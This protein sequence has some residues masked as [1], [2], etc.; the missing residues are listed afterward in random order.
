MTLLYPEFSVC[1]QTPCLKRRFPSLCYNLGAMA[2]HSKWAQI[3]RQKAVKDAK[4][5]AAFAKCAHEIMKATSLGGPDPAGNFRLRTAIEKA[6][7][8][9]LPNDNIHRAIA[10]GSGQGGADQMDAMVYEGYGPGGAAILIEAMT[11]NKNRTAGDIRSYFNKCE[12]NLGADGCVAW[13]FKE[14]GLIKISAKAGDESVL[15]DKAIEA[16]AQDFQNSPEED[17][18]EILTAPADLNNVCER[19]NAEGLSI[20]S[21]EMTRTCENHVDITDLDHAKRLLKL[22]DLIESH[23]DVQAVYSNFEMSEAL[24]ARLSE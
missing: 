21:A 7:A 8:L 19:L 13:M 11:D 20:Q 16:G 1:E 18:F 5:G 17:C 22:L 6:K 23:D 15:F 14:Q 4:K 12:G 10:K 24:L 9:G 2:G 3:K